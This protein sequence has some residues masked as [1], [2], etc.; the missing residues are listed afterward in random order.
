MNTALRMPA[1]IRPLRSGTLRR[2]W[3]GQLVSG[4]GD[5]VFPVALTIAVLSVGHGPVGLG[6]VLTA[7]ATGAAAGSVVGGIAADRLG[8]VKSMIAADA[9]RLIAVLVLA[10]TYRSSFPL[11]VA[12][13]VPMGFGGAM[14]T[15]AYFALVPQL[16]EEG[17]LQASNGLRT[18][19][20][21]ITRLIGPALGG[22]I[23]STYSPRVA[24]VLDAATFLVSLMTLVGI[25]ESRSASSAKENVWQSAMKGISAV[26]GKYRW[27][28]VVILQG[29]FQMALVIGPEVILLPLVL[30]RWDRLSDYGWILAIQGF[31]TIVGSIW[32]SRWQPQRPGMT[33]ILVMLA[34]APE[35]IVLAANWPV[36]LLVVSAALTGWAYSTFA[37]FWGTALQREVPREV[38]SRVASLDSLGGYI[39][40]PASMAFTGLAVASAGLVVVIAVCLVVL[41]ASTIMPLFANGV[42]H[43]STPGALHDSEC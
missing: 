3:L 39:L 9:L 33:A 35:L 21:R 42:L 38:L 14:F 8:R 27:I 20:T 19:T 1:I 34:V 7:D 17:D 23:A 2:V 12:C 29:M 6:I 41:G 36:V 37:V 30:H 11:V 15:P 32:A 28:G 31:G 4:I 13:A 18:A 16:I 24:F 43:F 26:T 25:N 22:L 40:L 10:G 5:G